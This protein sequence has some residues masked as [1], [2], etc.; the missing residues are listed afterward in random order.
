MR[1][2]DLKGFDGTLG[3][4]GGAVGVFVRSDA[5]ALGGRDLTR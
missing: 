2:L 5:V 4:R 1:D 3:F